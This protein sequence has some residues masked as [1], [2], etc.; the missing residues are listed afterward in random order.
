M[1]LQD[2]GHQLLPCRTI[3]LIGRRLH[4]AMDVA[5]G[6]AKE[7][8]AEKAVMTRLLGHLLRNKTQRITTLT[9]NASK[10]SRLLMFHAASPCTQCLMF[11]GC[12]VRIIRIRLLQGLLQDIILAHLLC[13][14]RRPF[15]TCSSSS[16]ILAPGGPQV[17]NRTRTQALDCH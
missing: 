15:P 17:I 10:N 5:L 8:V 12:E 6:R 4:K 14:L 16:I 7:L 11:Q 2:R 3:I 9:K 13:G 1:V